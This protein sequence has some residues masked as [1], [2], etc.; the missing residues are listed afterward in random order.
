MMHMTRMRFRHALVLSVLLALPLP[1]ARAEWPGLQHFEGYVEKALSD[2]EVPG[3]GLAIVKDDKLVLA[4]GFGVRQLGSEAKVDERTLFAIGSASKAFTATLVG[5]LV[6]EGKAKWDDPASKHLPGFQLFD[7]YATRELTLRDLLCHRSGLERGDLLWYGSDLSRDQILEQVRFLEPAWSF[8][9]QF[10]YQNIMYVAAGQATAKTAGKSWDDLVKERIFRPLGMKSSNTSVKELAGQEDVASPHIK[11]ENTIRVIPW[12]NIDN[13]GPAGAI[14]SCAAEMAQWVR[15]QLGE[16]SFEGERLISSAALNETHMAQTVIR[17]EGRNAKL[18]PDTHLM[19]YGLGWFLMDYR[20]KLIVQHGGN[21]DGMSA[22]VAMIPEEKLGLVIL[23]NMGG[24]S[25][26]TALMFR[27]FD[28]YLRAPDRDWSGDLLTIVKGMEK[29]QEETVK[30]E[31]AKRV[32]GTKPSLELAKYAG[33]YEN[34]MYGK[35]T[36]ALEED[37]LVLRRPAAFVMDLEHWNFDTF[38]SISREIAGTKNFVTFRLNTTGEV[39]ELEIKELATF[40]RAGNEADTSHD[41]KLSDDEMRKFIGSYELKTPPVDLS[42]EWV[43]G[44]LKAIIAGQPPYTLVPV[45]PARFRLEGAPKGY[46]A[47]F[48]LE[49]GK[50]RSVT[51]EQGD[52]PSITMMVKEAAK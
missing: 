25:L 26:P 5:L 47:E 42:V 34:K 18:Y 4:K 6:D 50:P 22:L 19:S 8:R 3:L 11:V 16:G 52:R 15:L 49:E 17:V 28:G 33:S 20:G 7:P 27:I 37:K 48:K 13:V 38:R 10:G 35:I 29:E 12:R 24:T 43:G 2:W 36:V 39:S 14:N 30:K 51:I 40:K 21:I 44:K 45:G 46:Y 1:I 23:T 9:S 31:E 41:I 32:Q